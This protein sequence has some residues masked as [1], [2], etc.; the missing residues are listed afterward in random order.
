MNQNIEVLRAACDAWLAASAFREGRDRHKRFTY[1]DQWSEPVDDHAGHIVT[2]RD[3]LLAKGRRPLTNNLIRQMVKAIVGRYRN[4]AADTGRYDSGH[5]SV[6]ARNRLADLDARML[7]EFVISGC[8]VQRVVAESRPGG[9]GVWID[10]VNPRSFFV[11]RYTDPRGLDIEMI[12]MLHAMSLPE[13][14]NRFARGSASRAERLGR[15]FG[16]GA[17][18]RAFGADTSLGIAT[19]AAVD[20]FRAPAGKYRVIEVWTLDSRAVRGRGGRLH[21]QFV[22][23]CRWL[24]PDGTVVD[25]FDSPY[26][27]GSHPFVLRLYP[28]TDGE[29][30][31][32][33]EDVIDQQRAVNRLVVLIDTM[34]ASSA[35][36]TLLYPVRRLPKGMG[37][38]D[39]ARMWAA[40]DSVIPIDNTGDMPTQVI[41]N[42]ADSGAYQALNLQMRLMGEISGISDALLGRNVPAAT[43]AGLYDAQVRNASVALTDILETFVSFTVDRDEKVRETMADNC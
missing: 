15:L 20:F 40:P 11:S 18:D 37:L 32:F 8:A 25:E 12:G 42:T 28:L 7:E 13:I 16:G 35:K 1:G 19:P 39:V 2:E 6:A 31:S 23:R 21:M 34:M 4:M 41:S 26:R 10:N 24:A 9:A 43:G 33:V 17:G 22:W 5:D 14:I 27:H 3:L 29:I 36:G 30:H 38:D